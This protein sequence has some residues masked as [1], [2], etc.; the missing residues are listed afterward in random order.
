M[1][2]SS[3]SSLSVARCGLQKLRSAHYNERNENTEIVMSETISAHFDGKVIVPDEPLQLPI[4]QPLRVRMEVADAPAARFAEFL[5]F[6]ADL[7]DAPADL[8]AQH[9]HYLYGTPKQ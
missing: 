3:H 8:A 1:T 2:P 7:P 9:D 6:A 5:Q 4:G